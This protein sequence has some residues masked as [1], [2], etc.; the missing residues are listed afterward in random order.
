[1]AGTLEDYKKQ[2]YATADA[3]LNAAVKEKKK[4]SQSSVFSR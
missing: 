2:T 3:Q 4:Q 1:M